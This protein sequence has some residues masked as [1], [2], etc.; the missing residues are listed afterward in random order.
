M[1]DHALTHLQSTT[2]AAAI[3]GELPQAWLG[4][5]FP[6][7]ETIHVIAIATVFGSIAMVDLR[8]LGMVGRRSSAAQIAAEYLP[9]TWTAFAV[10]AFAGSLMFISKA[11]TYFHN[12]QFELKFLF[13]ALAGL[14]MLVFHCGAFRSVNRWNDQ[15]PPPLPARLAGGLS[16]LFWIV[17]IFFGRWTGFT[18]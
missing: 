14:N 10:A 9:I 6:N 2:L 11:V 1:L 5:L 4:W 15:L 7:I 16:L 8:L 12:L 18:T 13:M 17:V 3:R